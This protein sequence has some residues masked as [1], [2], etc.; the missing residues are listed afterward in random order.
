ML[1]KNHRFPDFS[2]NPLH[3]RALE[4]Q[5]QGVQIFDLTESNPTRLGLIY[6]KEILT[7]AMGNEFSWDYNPDPKGLK[8]A[9]E[10]LVQYYTK[11]YPHRKQHISPE[12][13]WIA[14][15]TSELYSYVFKAITRPGDEV[16]GEVPGYPLIRS[17][18][19]LESCRFLPIEWRKF[20]SP[21][22]ALDL[23]VSS[24]TRLICLVSPN[25]P[26]GKFLSQ[27]EYKSILDWAR[28]YG[29]AVLIDEVF[30]EYSIRGNTKQFDFFED[31]KGVEVFILNGISKM[32]ALPGWKL[33]WI[34]Y[35]SSTPAKPEIQSR[36]DWI[37]DSFLSCHSLSQELLPLILE[38]RF[39]VQ[40]QIKNR[41]QRN[42][43]YAERRLRSWKLDYG[44]AGWYLGIT[45]TSNLVKD[46]E[47]L[48]LSLLENQNILV[49]P[50]S[51]FGYP[52]E[53]PHSILSLIVEESTFQ[54]AIERM[55]GN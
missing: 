48:A 16:I 19:E 6:P 32:A 50:G 52:Q 36:L 15:G 26:S 55:E 14:S 30:S 27:E 24:R 9:R 25:N 37:G 39:L 54:E 17:L 21:R 43:A 3:S 31:A 23:V 35:I 7:Y 42:L 12:D 4:L 18:A 46:S 40:N 53:F 45:K 20:E 28:G 8:R 22:Q 41:I 29:I 38:S 51:A 1:P 2:P 33:G 10:A 5:R 47:E 11:T 44:G 49:Y 13:F 34:F